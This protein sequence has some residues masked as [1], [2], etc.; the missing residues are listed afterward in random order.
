MCDIRN[1]MYARECR[2]WHSA[3]AS[4]YDDKLRCFTDRL[5][6][7]NIPA[8]FMCPVCLFRRFSRVDKT[9]EYSQWRNIFVLHANHPELLTKWTTFYVGFLSGNL[10]NLVLCTLLRVKISKHTNSHKRH[11]VPE[12]RTPL[13][14]NML[15]A[16]K[17]N[18]YKGVHGSLKMYDSVTPQRQTLTATKSLTLA[19]H[20]TKY[21]HKYLIFPIMKAKNQS[22]NV[23][24]LFVGNL[25]DNQ[26]FRR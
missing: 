5:S 21:S 9:V 6:I 14:N 20:K 1:H 7:F 11:E 19:T 12:I 24:I 16:Q 22:Q 17:P 10:C 15:N 2:M 3:S 25:N 18:V 23:N 13:H 26:P 8:T 4:V